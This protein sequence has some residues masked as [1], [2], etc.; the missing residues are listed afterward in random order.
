M[1]KTALTKRGRGRAHAQT[2]THTHAQLTI[3]INTHAETDEARG[4]LSPRDSQTPE[5]DSGK[6]WHAHKNAYVMFFQNLV[7]FKC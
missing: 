4:A 6:L 3:K 1:T 7:E 5:K 2:H